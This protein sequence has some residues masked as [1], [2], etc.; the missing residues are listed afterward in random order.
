[1]QTKANTDFRRSAILTAA[2]VLNDTSVELCQAYEET[3]DV[4]K[5]EEAFQKTELGIGMVLS[6]GIFPNRMV[7]NLLGIVAMRYRSFGNE[8]DLNIGIE[9]GNA[10]VKILQPDHRL[11]SDLFIKLA[12]LHKLKYDS[13]KELAVLDNCIRCTKLALSAPSLDSSSQGEIQSSMSELL[14]IRHSRTG[15]YDD[16]NRSTDLAG[17][18]VE[19]THETHPE[20][21]VRKARLARSLR[22]Q[23]EQT[24]QISILTR[25]VRIMEEALLAAPSNDPQRARML[26][27]LGKCLGRYS[28]WTGKLDDLDR[29]IKVISDAEELTQ[30]GHGDRLSIL[31]ELAICFGER[32][33][34]TSSLA[35]LN[36]AIA[37]D[38]EALSIDPCD[39][40]AAHSLGCHLLS[41]FE[42]SGQRQ[43]IDRSIELVEIACGGVLPKSPH[44][45]MILSTYAQCLKVRFTLTSEISDLNSAIEAG[46]KAVLGTPAAYYRLPSR[47]ISLSDALSIRFV[48]LDAI[49]DLE[50][51]IQLMGELQGKVPL[52]HPEQPDLLASYGNKLGRRFERNGNL[53]DINMAVEISSRAVA[54]T[55]A[56]A[57]TKKEKLSNLAHW[58]AMRFERTGDIQDINQAIETTDE[59]LRE[60]PVDH[61][62]RP[63]IQG[64]LGDLLGRRF[65]RFGA[66]E[67][68]MR[69]IELNA[70]AVHSMPTGNVEHP[71]RLNSLAGWYFRRFDRQGYRQFH[72]DLD[73]AIEHQEMAI[74]ELPKNHP[75]LP[76]FLNNLGTQLGRRSLISGSKLDLDKAIQNL[77][78]GAGL[79]PGDHA[80]RPYLLNSLAVSLLERYQG[81]EKRE[82]NDIDRTIDVLT[83]VA[84]TIDAR[85][86]FRGSI[87]LNLGDS[88]RT[89]YFGVKE[90]SL[91]DRDR[92]INNFIASLHCADSTPSVRIQAARHAA[93]LLASLSRWKESTAIFRQAV[94]LFPLL[95][96]RS[97]ER[98]DQQHM[99]SK[100]AGIASTAAAV[101]LNSESELSE[102]LEF[103]ELGRGVIARLLL[104][105][106]MDTSDFP[107]ELA[108][109]FL[110]AM[111]ELDVPNKPAG[112]GLGSDV[113]IWVSDAKRRYSAESELLDVIRMLQASPD[114][115]SGFLG[116]PSIDEQKKAIGSDTVVVINS[117]IFRSDAFLINQKHGIRLARLENLKLEEVKRRAEQIRK[118][119]PYLDPAILEWM[120][121]D[122]VEPI[123]SELGFSSVSD[124]KELP[125]V[126]WVLVGPMSHLPLHAAGRH[127]KRSRETTMDRVISSYSLSLK[128]FFDTRMQKKRQQSK[129]S[130]KIA[131]LV[132]VS[133]SSLILGLDDLPFAAREVESLEKLC[134]SLELKPRRI[135][136]PSREEIL[137][138]LKLCSIFHFAGHGW[139]DPHNPSGSGLLLRDGFLTVA[140]LRNH[141]ISQSAPF[142]GYLSACWTGA[143]DADE[144]VDEG[145]H[146]INACQL[147]GF[148]H[149]IG[150]LWQVSDMHCAGVTESV[151]EE[152]ARSGWNDD[153]VGLG[154]H[155][156]LIKFR[157]IWVETQTTTATERDAKLRR[158]QVSGKSLV[159]LDW[160]PYVHFGP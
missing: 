47:I 101:A 122:I 13:S 153:S 125:R 64:N 83:T 95:S 32:Y 51:S 72:D 27:D 98:S 23:F 77:D 16:L 115:K 6:A 141:N 131:L 49:D 146:L 160:V 119:R 80:F 48:R 89:R 81:A 86:H 120:W 9:S 71:G 96:P 39:S 28:E 46:R 79:L 61:P 78:Q 134:P 117:S 126:W 33:E 133:E 93:M 142:L 139:L 143:T 155:K 121:D 82:M 111:A 85:H 87:L 129:Q 156:A 15:S 145:I 136:E 124:D 159:K 35:D 25:S 94:G 123:L 29:A 50:E 148:R 34:Q 31:V 12:I 2:S 84:S 114:M 69:A 73:R 113:S 112:L 70:A 99:L 152:I 140:D 144:L 130:E 74:S 63:G 100:I 56:N 45:A 137:E 37:Y 106:R 38:N 52:D 92:A 110:S 7:V 40:L 151:Y 91:D 104:E 102:S 107:P 18:A 57:C 4:I 20:L 55:T 132:G 68:L 54:G 108:S 10:A 118:N 105:M 24:S 3:G 116:L 17:L 157:D 149:V 53:V 97:L 158:A 42:R 5:V 22:V 19:A 67:D 90:P 41:R 30:L 138:Q 128:A 135:M 66:L 103:L 14:F 26:L 58:L 154:L 36:Q 65:E 11:R 88:Y 76:F 60:T 75:T 109:R 127:S 43:D 1:M 21:A 44:R 8:D 150:T 62:N 59:A 147:A